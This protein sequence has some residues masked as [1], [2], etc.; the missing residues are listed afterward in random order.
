MPSRKRPC[1]ISISMFGAIVGGFLT[2]RAAAWVESRYPRPCSLAMWEG[3]VTPNHP[4]GL[5]PTKV[6]FLHT[7]VAVR[8]ASKGAA[9]AGAADVQG[10]GA[11]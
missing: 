8:F 7:R 2:P 10:A 4:L 6:N 3:F 11:F 9:C 5:A 1:A